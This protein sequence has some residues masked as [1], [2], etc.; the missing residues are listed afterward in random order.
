MISYPP[1]VTEMVSC[2]ALSCAAGNSSCV[3][4]AASSR[5]N[6]ACKRW[7]MFCIFIFLMD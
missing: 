2:R 7:Y 6:A 1:S 4:E 3:Q 5:S